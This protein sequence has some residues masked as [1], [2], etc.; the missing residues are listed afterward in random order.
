MAKISKED[1]E[2]QMT[3]MIDVVFQLIIFFIV[4]IKMNEQINE[5]IILEDA[6]YGEII[7]SGDQ[8]T[9]QR[10][11]TIEV[12]RRGWVTIQNVPVTGQQLRGIVQDRYNRY[13]DAFSLMIRGDF[14][15]QHKD[16]RKVMDICSAI[17]IWRISFVAV[18]EHKY[19]AGRHMGPKTRA[20]SY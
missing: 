4:T 14:R 15:S 5:D 17:G 12:D 13:R 9:N 8:A 1:A 18:Q 6:P 16:I 11:L 3:P 20:Y 10:V 19:T 7:E 2:L